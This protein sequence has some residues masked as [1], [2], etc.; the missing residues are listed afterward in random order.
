MY[1][2]GDLVINAYNNSKSNIFVKKGKL[3]GKEIELQTSPFLH[4]AGNTCVYHHGNAIGITC[5]YYFWWSAGVLDD[6]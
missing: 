6:Q 1:I 2:A 3:N 4:H 5:R